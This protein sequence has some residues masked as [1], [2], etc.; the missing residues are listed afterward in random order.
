MMGLNRRKHT[1][2]LM[3]CL[4]A[5]ATVV[6]VVGDSTPARSATE[7][8]EGTGAELATITFAS[9]AVGVWPEGGNAWL[10]VQDSRPLHMGDHVRTGEESRAVIEFVDG[11][12]VLL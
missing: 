8:S 2:L 6:G 4:M 3:V 5:L 11:S 1:T 7:G 9:G 12:E 10:M